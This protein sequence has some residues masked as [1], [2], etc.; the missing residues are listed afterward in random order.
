M[1]VAALEGR[2]GARMAT[3]PGATPVTVARVTPTGSTFARAGFS[4]DHC[5]GSAWPLTSVIVASRGI[6]PPTATV[7]DDRLTVTLSFAPLDVGPSPPPPHASM[8][9]TSAQLP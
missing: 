6:T 4:L 9:M 8:P 2:G 3:E 5:S 7:A 1:F